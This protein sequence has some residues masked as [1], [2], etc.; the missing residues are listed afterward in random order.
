MLSHDDR[1]PDDRRWF[2]AQGCL[3]SEFPMTVETAREAAAHGEHTVFGAPN[4]VRGGSHVG[5]PSAAEMAGA[6]LCTILASDYY[7][8]A[9]PAAPFRLAANGVLPLEQAWSLVSA[10][11]AAALGLSD[12]GEIAEGRRA[13]LV[14]VD[15]SDPAGPRIVATMVAGRFVFLADAERLA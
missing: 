4:V 9:L 13:D 10:N 11:P 12:R 6:G 2:R 7:Y 3:V 15:A 1:S 5:C 14:L 8:P